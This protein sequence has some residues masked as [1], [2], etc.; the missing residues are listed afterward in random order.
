MAVFG[1]AFR[2][3]AAPPRPLPENWNGASLRVEGIS[4]SFDGLRVLQAISFD[5]RCGEVLGLIGPNGAGKTT[6]LNILSGVLKPDSGVITLDGANTVFA[7]PHAAV[8]CGISRTF[9][10]LRIFGGLSVAE[11]LAIVDP[12]LVEPLLHLAGLAAV[13]SAY[14][15]AL[16][17]GQQRRLEIARALALRP[18]VLLLD[19]PTAGMTH[20]ESREIASVVRTLREAGLTIVLVE[21]NLPFMMSIADRVV[22]L[23][24]GRLIAQGSSTEVLHDPAVV[25]AYLGRPML[26]GRVEGTRSS[27]I[28][29]NPNA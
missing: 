24:A 10:N 13:R 8:R 5:V 25:E 3:P 16:P 17:Y 4:K 6:L 14:A 27:A 26:A 20:E 23:D 18:R 28:P 9:Q 7:A 19:E 11:N 15:G 2:A 1:H 21:H 29:A 12:G 22:V